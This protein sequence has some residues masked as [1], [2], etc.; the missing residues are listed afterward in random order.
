MH[1][2]AIDL[3]QAAGICQAA[4]RL[5]SVPADTFWSHTR[6]VVVTDARRLAQMALLAIEME[7]KACA[8]L[9]DLDPSAIRHAR[10]SHQDLLLTVPAY[11]DAW[12]TLTR[13]QAGAENPRNP[14]CRNLE[15]ASA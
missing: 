7:E 14:Q 6:R 10:A 13:R 2:R 9:F 15:T 8:E 1:P 5:Y 4:M 12:E 3:D 11:R